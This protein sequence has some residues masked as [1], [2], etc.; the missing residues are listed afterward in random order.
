MTSYLDEDDVSIV[1]AAIIC[2]RYLS[3]L[4]GR[5]EYFAIKHRVQESR[6]RRIETLNQGLRRY[7]RRGYE[8][9]RLTHAS[10][11]P[12]SRVLAQHSFN[13]VQSATFTFVQTA[14]R[15]KPKTKSNGAEVPEMK[16]IIL[17]AS[18]I[19]R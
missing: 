14:L 16:D 11:G 1:F 19:H 8:A 2:T 17:P 10:Y 6:L 4:T 7:E 12:T 9:T 3:T 18:Q 13:V 15:I 5:Y